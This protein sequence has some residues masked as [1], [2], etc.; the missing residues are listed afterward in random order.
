VLSAGVLGLF[1]DYHEFVEATKKLKGSGFDDISLMSPIPLEGMEEILGEKKSVIKRFT[2]LG[3]II[4]ALSGFL[5][6][7]GTSVYYILPTGGRPIIT[8]PPFLLISYEVTILF[9][10]LFTLVGFF[11]SSRLP[12]LQDR[13]YSYETNVDNFG[14]LVRCKPHDNEQLV[15][16]IMREAGADDIIEVEGITT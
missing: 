4:G 1:Q 3:G 9:G 8:Y 10:I 16:D 6:A 12:A 2:F 13:T 5:L 11:I 15:E 7:A 14:I